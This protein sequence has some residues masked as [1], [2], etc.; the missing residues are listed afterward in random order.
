[1]QDIR[2]DDPPKEKERE[3]SKKERCNMYEMYDRKRKN[4]YI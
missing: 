4:S 3:N 2:K 1:M